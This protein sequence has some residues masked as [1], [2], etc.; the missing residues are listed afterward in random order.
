MFECWRLY[1]AA[2]PPN[3]PI[4]EEMAHSLKAVRN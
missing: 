3:A 1:L 4:N 2:A